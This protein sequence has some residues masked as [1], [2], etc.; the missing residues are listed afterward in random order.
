MLGYE[1][2]TLDS[3]AHW[4][5]GDDEGGNTTREGGAEL[6]RANLCH[7]EAVSKEHKGVG[8]LGDDHR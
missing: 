6:L 7:E 8:A 3:D 4:E 2:G 5:T 1:G